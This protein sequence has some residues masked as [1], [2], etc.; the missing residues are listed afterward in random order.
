[1]RYRDY[2]DKLVEHSMIKMVAHCKVEETSYEWM[3]D[4]CFEVLKPDIKV[5]VGSCVYHSLSMLSR[6]R[7]EGWRAEG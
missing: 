3:D 6:V 5:Q 2:Y 7:T 1:M 4:D